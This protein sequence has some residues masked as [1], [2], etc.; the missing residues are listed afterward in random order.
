[1]LKGTAEKT[2]GISQAREGYATL[3]CRKGP[4]MGEEFVRVII[5]KKPR[6]LIFLD[7][8]ADQESKALEKFLKEIPGL[9]IVILDHHIAEKDMNSER[10]LHINPRFSNPGVYMPAACMVYRM[11]EG[12]G[13][14]VR[15]LIWIAAMGV[16][17]DY[18]WN[19][20]PD[21][22]KEA[23]EEYPFL[24]EGEPNR[25][26]LGEGGDIISAATTLKGLKGVAECLKPLLKAE[27]FED[28]ES[29]RKLQDWKR[30]F[31]DELAMIM[32]DFQKKKQVLQEE[33]L[34]IYEVKSGLNITSTV[35]TH[36]GEKFP[37]HTV[38]IWKAR[39]S[40]NKVSLRNQSGKLNLG[41]LVKEAVKGIGSGGGH[42]K[43]AAGVVTDWK[44]FLERFRKGLKSSS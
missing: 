32:D 31:D 14:E 3:P 37:E 27:G 21:L 16:I 7:L 29:V 5:S 40:G 15:S 11:L 23:R 44:K 18:G 13:L 12:L 41:D 9:R 24:L 10:V 33:K 4:I 43:A 35:A 34:I 36:L 2:E 30:Q 42:E 28:F 8:P 25:S 19:G 38:M 20:C 6:L 17:G 39:E 22:I 26:K 1:L